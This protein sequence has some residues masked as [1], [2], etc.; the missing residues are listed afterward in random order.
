MCLGSS[1]WHTALIAIHR[2]IVV[3]HN[4]L[5]KAMNIKAYIILVLVMAR[6][7]P[8]ACA[9]PGF[10]LNTSGYM[11]K[12]LRCILLPTQ[13]GRIVSVTIIQVSPSPCQYV[14]I[15]QV[16]ASPLSRSVRHHYLGQYVTIIQ[17]C[18]SPLFRSVRHHHPGKSVTKSVRHHYPGQY[19]TII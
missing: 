4:S 13:K 19:V 9:L 5:Y 17:V 1:L 14:T 11:P 2:Y 3:V 18:T 6:V 10:N 7:I 16:S 12:M 15:I 8:I